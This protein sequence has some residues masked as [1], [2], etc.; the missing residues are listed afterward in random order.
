MIFACN[1]CDAVLDDGGGDNST[2]QMA[3]P[4]GISAACAE[5]C[6]CASL[7]CADDDA[8]AKHRSRW[9]RTR[10]EMRAVDGARFEHEA[11]RAVNPH[12][13]AAARTID[14][15][16]A[17]KHRASARHMAKRCLLESV[18]ILKVV[19]IDARVSD[20]AHATVTRCSS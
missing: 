15:H 17:V 14:N 8:F 16:V 9:N 10:S 12:D 1:E 2:E 18:A 20:D 5:C 3:T 13:I 19:H 7:T 4:H 11:I 6:D